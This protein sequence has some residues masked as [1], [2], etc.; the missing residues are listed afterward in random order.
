MPAL[1]GRDSQEEKAPGRVSQVARGTAER[2]G[3]RRGVGY[4]RGGVGRPRLKTG[5][6]A[7]EVK[8]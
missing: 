3:S 1:P 4:E 5:Q 7:P 2:P 6:A 8:S